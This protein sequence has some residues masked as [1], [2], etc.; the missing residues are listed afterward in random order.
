M[1]AWNSLNTKI[2]KLKLNKGLFFFFLFFFC[3]FISACLVSLPLKW[4]LRMCLLGRQPHRYLRKFKTCTNMG[5]KVQTNYRIKCPLLLAG[6]SGQTNP[7]RSMFRCS[8]CFAVVNL[9]VRSI[10][11]VPQGMS[12]AGAINVSTWSMFR[13]S[14]YVIARNFFISGRNLTY[15][16]SESMSRWPSSCWSIKFNL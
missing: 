1:P 11:E 4:L 12:L 14:R 15:D 3:Y 2:L 10:F 16:S 9:L 13:C 6:P 5:K 7:A 8:R